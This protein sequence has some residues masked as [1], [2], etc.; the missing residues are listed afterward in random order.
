MNYEL[1]TGT[2]GAIILVVPFKVKLDF[3]NLRVCY[4]ANFAKIVL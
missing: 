1:S 4:A 3:I 2:I